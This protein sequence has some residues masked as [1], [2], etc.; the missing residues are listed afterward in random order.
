[1]GRLNRSG[2]R[3]R[4][5]NGRNTKKAAERKN[6]GDGKRGEGGRNAITRRNPWKGYKG[7]KEKRG[8]ESER[9]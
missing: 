2:P 4:G 6:K 5:R 7:E 1:M 9:T 8:R 3:G